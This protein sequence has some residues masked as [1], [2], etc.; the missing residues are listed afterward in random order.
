MPHGYLSDEEG[1]QDEDE[2]P[3]SPSAAKEKLKLKEEQ[4]ERE[5]KEKTCHI[6]PSLIGCCWI[7][8]LNQE[9]QLLKVLQRYATVVFSSTTPIKLSCSELI[10][11]SGESPIADDNARSEKASKR[12]VSDTDIPVLIRV[13]HGSSYSKLTIIKEFLLHL[14]RNR[15]EENKN[16]NH[17]KA[18]QLNICYT[19]STSLNLGPSKTQ[20]M[21]KIADIASWTK[22]TEAGTMNGRTCWI[23][24]ADVLERYNLTDLSAINTWEFAT[25]T[26]K[27]GRKADDSRTE[28]ETPPAKTPRV[29]LV[30]KF[31]QPASATP[32]VSTPI[33]TNPKETTTEPAKPPASTPKAKKRIT[34]ISVPTSATKKP[35]S[36]PKS[37]PLTNFLKKI[38][39]KEASSKAPDNADESLEMD[40]VEVI[41]VEWDVVPQ[42]FLN[43][44]D[45]CFISSPKNLYVE[46]GKYVF[47]NVGYTEA[48]VMLFG[49]PYTSYGNIL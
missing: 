45:W 34:L 44:E 25:E 24:N 49:F 42:Q 28:E 8:D 33:E 26:K 20:I 2:R 4:F 29:S 48:S 47:E 27:R 17:S 41:S 31:A 30:K 40:G 1:E 5:L 36:D 39:T 23:V 37:T 18:F 21:A 15:T 7:D 9:P 11:E 46:T 13:L 22:C 3:L 16:G 12:L 38:S 19:K 35:K 6:K 32:K 10:C 14:E 43:L